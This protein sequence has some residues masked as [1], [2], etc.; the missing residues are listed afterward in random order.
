MDKELLKIILLCGT[1]L[2]LGIPILVMIWKG[3]IAELSASKDKGLTMLM[4][5]RDNR[6]SLKH[7]MDRRIVELDK[8]LSV[9][10][11]SLT[12]SLRKPILSAVA[13]ATLCSAVLRALVA[14]LREP[15]ILAVEENN[16]KEALST[17]K[18]AAYV[19]DK[20]F[21]MAQEYADLVKEATKDPCVNGATSVITYPSW[22][23][24]APALRAAL[25]GWATGIAKAVVETCNKKIEVYEEYKSLFTELQDNQYVEVANACIAKN[26]LYIKNLTE[27]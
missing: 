13:D 14:D 24:I 15:L 4:G 1:A 6:D 9:K 21:L 19:S 8:A 27:E 2:V 16:F 7:F 20:L 5:K 10:A 12:Q 11:R 17:G 23:E 22:N 18:R 25:E 3:K 26:N